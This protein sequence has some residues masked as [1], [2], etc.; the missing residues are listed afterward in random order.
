[1]SYFEC[2]RN[3]HNWLWAGSEPWVI[4]EL[5]LIFQDLS[6]MILIKIIL[7][8]KKR[9]RDVNSNKIFRLIGLFQSLMR[10]TIR[11]LDI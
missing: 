5:F 6:L 8:K 10:D 3:I 2:N 9:V 1:M 4:L 11:N 7:I